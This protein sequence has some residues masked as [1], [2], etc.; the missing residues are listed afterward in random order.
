MT[1]ASPW[2]LLGLAVLPLLAALYVW[3]LRRPA[4]A[5]DA[6]AAPYLVASVQPHRPGWRRH[7]PLLVL[8]AAL[9][10]LI[11]AGAR[12]QRSVAVPV[13]QASI[14]LATD[15]SG[16]MLATDVAP[17]RLTAAK[18]ATLAFLDETPAKV[19]VG[20]M[21]FNQRPT[22]L[23]SPTTD[24]EAARVAVNGEEA[25]GGTA[26]GD[27]VEAALSMVGATRASDGGN[28]PAAIVLLSDGK[29]KRGVDPIEAATKAGEQKVPV[30]TVALGTDGATLNT[31]TP[32]GRTRIA[33]VS[34]D[35]TTLRAM[36]EASGGESFTVGGASRL[37][38]VYE[39]LGSQLSRTTEKRQVTAWFVGGGLLMLLVAGGMS[40]RWFGRLV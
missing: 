1:F 34:P 40:L 3:R 31:K 14:V 5:G 12:P 18:R 20:I 35:P 16:S 10:V 28:P 6:F 17:D 30:Y 25:S 32:R 33:D 9:G 26:T 19:K 11:V 13:E 38:Q 27:A 36:A 21:A 37:D 7:V 15:V 39:R 4:R 2:V 22:V 23:Q 24:R 29:S 8:L